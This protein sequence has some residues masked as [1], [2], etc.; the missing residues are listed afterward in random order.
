MITLRVS[1]LAALASVSALVGCRSAQPAPAP[2]VAEAPPAQTSPAPARTGGPATAQAGGPV[3]H[4]YEISAIPRS[5]VDSVLRANP[6]AVIVDVAR[7]PSELSG[8]VYHIMLVDGEDVRDL[9]VRGRDA[10]I[11]RDSRNYKKEGELAALPQVV[12]S[13]VEQTY[14]NGLIYGAEKTSEGY[15]VRVL[16]DGG[17]LEAVCAPDGRLIRR[18]ALR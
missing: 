14:P 3:E 16:L 2:V 8:L 10:L 1:A 12:R 6:N 9:I 18:G 13:T 11:L 7:D 17:Q 4:V 5:V 15:A